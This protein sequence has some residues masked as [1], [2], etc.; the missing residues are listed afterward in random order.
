[1]KRLSLICFLLT[2]PLA[3]CNSFSKKSPAQLTAAEPVS[4][5][6]AEAGTVIE[7][8]DKDRAETAEWLRSSPRSYLAAV[9]R[10]DF[11]QKPALTVGRATDS[12]VRLESPDIE[13]HH[14]R[15][16]VEGDRF[17]VAALDPKAGFKVGEE[18]K[19]EA[20]LDPSYI[21]IG[22]FLLR[23]S[24]QRFPAI[25]VFDPQ[26]P[27]F[28]DYKGLSYFPIDLSYR[29][30]LPLTRDPA[31][32]KIIILSTRG[33]RRNAVR[34]GWFAFLI[35]KKAY[36]LEATRLLEPGSGD[37]DIGVY[38]RDAT[39]GKESYGVGRYVNAVKLGNGKYLLDFNQAYNP[40]CAFSNF[41]NCPVPPKGNTL[42]AAIRA[43]E[44][45]AHYH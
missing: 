21:Q 15:I 8:I 43:G 40:A 20:V 23:L 34:V 28:K 25:I 1:M 45:D 39:S 26:S 5:S 36:R 2:L 3:G 12:D 31:S 35:G 9:N 16:T 27:R 37:D 14:L 18:I 24:H 10:V 42:D 38:F 11:G 7:G 17:R 30:E 6:K 19:R 41:Y 33:N 4:L 32:E 22:R 44:M 29:Y 13:L